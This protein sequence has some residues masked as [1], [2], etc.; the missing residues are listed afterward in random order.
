MTTSN[1]C[2]GVTAIA[3]IFGAGATPIAT[4]QIAPLVVS[5]VKIVPLP[6]KMSRPTSVVA[7]IGVVIGAGG[8]TQIAMRQVALLLASMAQTVSPLLKLSGPTL[9]V[10]ADG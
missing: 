4:T 5:V 2:G 6:S 9:A 3:A 10:V 8:A 1:P 7:T